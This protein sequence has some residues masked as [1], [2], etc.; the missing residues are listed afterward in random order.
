MC[1]SLRAVHFDDGLEVLGKKTVV[2]RQEYEG[3]V[4]SGSSVKSVRLPPTLKKIELRTFEDCKNLASVEFPGGVEYIGEACFS[5]SG[6][7]QITFPSTL[8]EVDKNAFKCC[9]DLGVVC[10]EKGCA[11]GVKKYLKSSV[12]VREK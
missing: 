2:N 5:W 4:F 7:K 9:F 6:V 8:R 3:R 1:E 11:A 10:V 12:E